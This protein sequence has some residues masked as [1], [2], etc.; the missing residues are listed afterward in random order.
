MNNQAIISEITAEEQAILDLQNAVEN[1]QTEVTQ[2][3]TEIFTLQTENA[4]LKSENE[5]LLI[6]LETV[7]TARLELPAFSVKTS[8]PDKYAALRDA[9]NR[10]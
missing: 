6:E 7:K 8:T 5:T 9:I 3:K 1:L 2:L 10:K 4:K